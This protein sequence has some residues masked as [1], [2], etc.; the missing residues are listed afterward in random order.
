VEVFH[1]GQVDQHLACELGKAVQ[2]L[3]HH[4]Q[5]EGAGAADVVAGDDLRDLADRVLHLA[6]AFAGVAVGVQPHEG[7]HAH[8]D[9]VAVDLGVV[10]LDVARLFQRPHAPPAGRGRQAHALREFGVGQAGI[11]LQFLQD[12]HVELV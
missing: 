1:V 9:L 8:A 10:A 7:Q 2:V 4:L 5:L 11:G 3:R 6:R 12:L